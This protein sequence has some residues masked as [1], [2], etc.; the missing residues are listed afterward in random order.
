MEGKYHPFDYMSRLTLVEKRSSSSKSPATEA[1]YIRPRG[2]GTTTDCHPSD[3]KSES[4]LDKT[5]TVTNNSDVFTEVEDTL[6]DVDPT[7]NTGQLYFS[8][9][10]NPS[11]DK[12]TIVQ[13]VVDHIS[14]VLE[15]IRADILYIDRCEVIE[16]LPLF[17]NSCSLLSYRSPKI[18]RHT[19]AN[20]VLVLLKHGGR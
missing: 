3:C 7:L 1:A 15:K 16:V 20:F 13:P 10:S 8:H 14:R 9:P 18:L 5:T 12:P 11:F 6:S 19:L 2:T 17:I 4:F